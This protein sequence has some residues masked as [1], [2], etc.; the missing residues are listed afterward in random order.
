MARGILVPQPGIEPVHAAVDT[1]SP[2][3]WTTREITRVVLKRICTN[4]YNHHCEKSPGLQCC[5]VLGFYVNR[6]SCSHI[7]I[8]VWE[9]LWE[10]TMKHKGYSCMRQGSPEKQT[11]RIYVDV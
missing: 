4:I 11:N 2:N 7:A 10:N 9:V 3:L 1:K 5:S 6:T 8:V